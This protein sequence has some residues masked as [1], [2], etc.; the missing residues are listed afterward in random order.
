MMQASQGRT[1]ISLLA[2]GASQTSGTMSMIFLLYNYN[3]FI[4]YHGQYHAAVSKLVINAH[5]FAQ[6]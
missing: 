6:R 2:S 5:N 3:I 1:L 4:I